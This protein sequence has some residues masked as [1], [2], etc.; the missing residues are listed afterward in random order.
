VTAK[1]K[2]LLEELRELN[3]RIDELY[4]MR[5]AE[6]P[7]RGPLWEAIQERKAK[8]RELVTA[9]ARAGAEVIAI[10]EA[11]GLSRPRVWELARHL[12]G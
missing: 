3:A 5:D 4:E 12:P 7:R 10:A 9:A 8:R 11:S 2:R 6:A 1:Q